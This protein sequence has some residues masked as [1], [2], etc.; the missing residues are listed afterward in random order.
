MDE[1][2]TGLDSHSAERLIQICRKLTELGRTVIATIHQPS[3]A[4]ADQFDRL[5]LMANKKIVYNGDAKQAL[6]FFA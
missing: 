6:D 1:P 2:T 5:M 4:M 3:S